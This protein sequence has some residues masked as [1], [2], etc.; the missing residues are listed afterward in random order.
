M[1]TRLSPTKGNLI[2]TK[3][4]MQLAKLGYDLMDRKRNVLIREM[5]LLVDKVKILRDQITQTYAEAYLSLQ[6][7]NISLGVVTQIASAVSIENGVS[8]VYR[9]VMGV[10][11]PN[12]RL[13]DTELTFEYGFDESN[14]K[15]DEASLK[16]LQAKRMTVLLAEIDNSVFRL[17][18]AIQKTQKRANALRNIVL[19]QLQDDIKF[20]S[21]ALEEKEREEFTRLKVIK[22]K[23][24][25]A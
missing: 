24:A 7:A 21:D 6:Q 22:N 5:M 23:K 11:I 15:L 16:F 9:S 14:S 4:S 1:A 12:V 17:A 3:K 18:R 8:I 20:I 19:P 25:R 2:A 10:E 13:E